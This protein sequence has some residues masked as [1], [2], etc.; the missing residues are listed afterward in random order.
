MAY[1]LLAIALALVVLIK[2]AGAFSID[3]TVAWRSRKL[4]RGPSSDPKPSQA[5]WRQHRQAR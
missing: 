5:R 4:T 1:Q 2:G 3:E